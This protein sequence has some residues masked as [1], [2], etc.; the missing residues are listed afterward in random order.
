M[1]GFPVVVGVSTK[2][3][4]DRSRGLPGRFAYQIPWDPRKQKLKRLIATAIECPFMCGSMLQ[5]FELPA[6]TT[7]MGR[8]VAWDGDKPVLDPMPPGFI[9]LTCENCEIDWSMPGHPEGG[10]PS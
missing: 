7:L 2:S 9:I 8:I 1:I 6:G 3:L 5:R 4:R 10:S